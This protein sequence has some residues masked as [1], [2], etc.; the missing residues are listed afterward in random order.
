MKNEQNVS[1]IKEVNA[2]DNKV[3]SNVDSVNDEVLS[4]E[5]E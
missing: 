1:N 5:D 3:N 2:K 4:S